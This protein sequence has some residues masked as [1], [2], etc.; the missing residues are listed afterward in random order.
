MVLYLRIDKALAFEDCD[1]VITKESSGKIILERAPQMIAGD[2]VDLVTKI[3]SYFRKELEVGSSNG[4]AGSTYSAP[5][6]GGKSKSNNNRGA[7]RSKSK[8]KSHHKK[9]KKPHRA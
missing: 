9:G 5:L 2:K 8:G 6:S 1:A 4:G 7:S 3:L